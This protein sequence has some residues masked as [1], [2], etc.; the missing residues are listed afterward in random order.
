VE[1]K[2][3]AKVKI[4]FEAALEKL[5]SIA[6]VL[7]DGSLGLEESIA[8]F[9]KGIKL[10]KYCHQKLEEAE[11]KIELLQKGADGEVETKNVKVKE[12]TGEIEEDEDL[13]GSLL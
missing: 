1:K 7:E 9:E 4:S 10:A 2:Q 5:E 13:Q 8:E 12:D 11:R 3:T 6:R